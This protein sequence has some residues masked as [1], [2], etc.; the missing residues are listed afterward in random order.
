MI[1]A[2][3]KAVYGYNSR[4]AAYQRKGDFARAAADYGEVTRLA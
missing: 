4:G 1:K 2:D 3:P